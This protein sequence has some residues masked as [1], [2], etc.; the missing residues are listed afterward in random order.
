MY[1]NSSFHYIANGIYHSLFIYSPVD[2]HLDSCQ[3]CTNANKTAMNTCVQV[4]IWTCV[5]F[6][7]LLGKYPGMEWLDH[8]VEIC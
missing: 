6:S 8:M 7:F 4:F 5:F 2:G 1:S 3:F